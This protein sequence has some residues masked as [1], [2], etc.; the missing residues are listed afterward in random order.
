MKRTFLALALTLTLVSALA[1]IVSRSGKYY[2][3]RWEPSLQIPVEVR[4]LLLSSDIGKASR[5]PAWKFVRDLPDS[6]MMATHDDYK[7]TGYDRG[8]M[9]PAQDRS[10][11]KA[12]MKQTFFMSNVC[13]QVSRFNRGI[14]KQTENIE[15]GQAITH[16]RCHVL[17]MPLFFEKDT[18][19]IGRAHVAVP[20]A[21]LKIIYDINPDTIYNVFVLWNK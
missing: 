18:I 19:H 6:V 4:W 8:H 5:E 2:Y 3:S 11:T 16:G 9:C 7:K 10:S 1:Q 17:A 12:E 14:W 21:F 20:H 13:P 15:R